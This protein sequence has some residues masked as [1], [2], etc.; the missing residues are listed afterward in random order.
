LHR[1]NLLRTS[2]IL[3]Y[4]ALAGSAAATAGEVPVP[5]LIIFLASF[6][7]GFVLDRRP[8]P[9]MVLNTWL[10]VFLVLLGIAL[11]L[12]GV[13]AEN[14]FN[15]VLGIIFLVISA[16]LISPKKVRDILQL[17]LLNLL[18]LS[19]AAVSRWG[20][21]FGLL[22]LIETFLSVTGLVLV[23]GSTE[24]ETLSVR[25]ARHLFRWGGFITLGLFPAT[26]L[27]FLILPRPAGIFFAW[28]GGAVSRT[29]FSDRVTPG[30]VEAIKTEKLPAFRAR[31]LEGSPPLRPLWRGIVYDSYHEGAWEKRF[32]SVLEF[33]AAWGRRVSYEV[34]IEPTNA[35]YL[36]CIGLPV[37][38]T[39]DSLKPFPVSG[40]T[41][42]T[43]RSMEKRA[44]Y[45][46]QS[47][48]F[49]ALP[50]DRP[51]EDYLEIPFG[52]KAEL[53]PLARKLK[54]QG[55]FE[56]ARAVE[57][58]L[59][60][61][62]VYDLSP[63]EPNGDPVRYFLFESRR[64]HC[65]YFASA[66]V[67]LLRSLNIPARLVGGYV[68]GEWN[69]M[70]GYFL[71]RH[72]DAH[73]W[74]EAWIEDRGWISFDPTPSASPGAASR[75]GG[76]LAR[77]V[78]YLR[79]KWYYWV[80]G[81]DL[82]RQ[83]ELAKRTVSVLDSIR[84]GKID[85]KFSFNGPRVA[86]MAL[87]CLVPLLALGLKTA[88]SRYHNRPRSWGERFVCLFDRYGYR[89]RPGETLREFSERLEQDSG[90]R[91]NTDRFV[92]Y[93]YRHE[94]GGDKR[95]EMLQHLFRA[96]RMELIALHKPSA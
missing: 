94:Y 19:A 91:E 92:Q 15:R 32:R 96:I 11:S 44:L 72:S 67:L 81:Y 22:V 75:Q 85:L 93:Y 12:I 70:G 29:G 38:V 42:E 58:Y 78:D 64:G 3:F 83:L 57:S 34:L 56:T 52:L 50:P 27:F 84:S 6:A 26:I 49:Q 28:G 66:M 68:G 43:T 7:A 45:R 33:P 1:V 88:R 53:L 41:L 76:R 62:Y 5:A 30:A 18:V 2:G 73:T 71:V 46:V 79:L 17:Y 89:K 74:V 8:F 40:H 55:V 20:L 63:G 54:K 13:R 87:L 21:E 90:L 37:A 9:I 95:E 61:E 82:G 31:W 36:F 14:F 16:K 4:L 80:L 59:R 24:Q 86:V 35:T 48:D 77:T 65:E 69:E 25:H 10:L 47:L 23:Y 39:S 60:R 51:A